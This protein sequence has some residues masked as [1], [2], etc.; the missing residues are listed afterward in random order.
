MAE[1]DPDRQAGQ[2]AGPE[3]RTR[4]ALPLLRRADAS[5]EANR[6]YLLQGRVPQ[7]GCTQAAWERYARVNWSYACKRGFLDA[8]KGFSAQ[9][10]RARVMGSYW[11]LGNTGT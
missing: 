7:D 5:V 11:M 9:Y 6:R 1:C 10:A 3:L 8:V 2:Q 4:L